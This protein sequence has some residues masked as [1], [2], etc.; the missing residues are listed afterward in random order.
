ME[1]EW[2][3]FACELEEKAKAEGLSEAAKAGSAWKEWARAAFERGAGRA[4]RFTRAAERWDPSDTLMLDGTVTTDPLE[5]LKAEKVSLEKKWRLGEAGALKTF[6]A[7]GEE[8]PLISPKELREASLSF[9]THTAVGFDGFHPRHYS[10]LEEE[11]LE[12]LSLILG[13][14]ERLGAM[15]KAMM[16]FFIFFIAKAKGGLRPLALFPSPYRLWSRAR[17]GFARSWEQDNSRDYFCM[18]AERSCVDTVW[19]QALMCEAQVAEGRQAATALWDIS[20]YY[21]CIAHEALW[22]RGRQTFFPQRLLAL[23]LNMYQSARHLTFAG[24][25]TPPVCV[26]VGLPAGCVFATTLVKVH[27]LTVADPVVQRHPSV[28]FDFWVDDLGASCLGRQGDIVEDLPAALEDLQRMV[29]KDLGC[30]VALP[31][32]AILASDRGLLKALG[33]KLR[34][35]GIGGGAVAPAAPNLGIDFTCGKKRS[36]ARG[37]LSKM[38]ARRTRAQQR[39][40]RFLLIRRHGGRRARFLYQAGVQASVAFGA[41]VNGLSDSE[42]RDLHRH[43]GRLVK[44]W[45]RGRI[46]SVAL[47]ASGDPVAK[48]AVAPAVRWV[49]EVWAALMGPRSA[50]GLRQLT[51]SRLAEAWRASADRPPRTWNQVRGPIGA[52]RLA[53]GRVGWE[54]AEPFAFVD[55]KGERLVVTDFSPALMESLLVEAWKFRLERQAAEKV[56]HPSLAGRRLYLDHVLRAK[57]TA[58]Y[59]VDPWGTAVVLGAVCGSTWTRTRARA[60]G[61]DIDTTCHLCKDGEDDWY[62]RLWECS[63]TE[64]LRDLHA[65]RWLRQRAREAARDDPLFTRGLLAHPGDLFTARPAAD[66]SLMVFESMEGLT[67]EE[68]AF[69]GELFIDGSASRPA[70]PELTRA[71]CA[72]VGLWPDNS[73]RFRLLFPVWRQ[74]P[75]TSQAAEYVVGAATYRLAKEKVIVYS[76]CANVVRD[77]CQ[78]VPRSAL[79]MY[80]AVVRDKLKYPESA[81]RVEAFLKVRAH[82]S[83]DESMSDDQRR[84]AIGNDEAD[85]AA[86]RAVREC[87][88]P[89]DE[90]QV[91][92]AEDGIAVAKAIIELIRHLGKEWGRLPRVGRI[93]GWKPPVLGARAAPLEQPGPRHQPVPIDPGGAI[94]GCGWRCSVCGA[95]SVRKEKLEQGEC[96]GEHPARPVVVAAPTRTPLHRVS[97]ALKARAHPSHALSATGPFL[98]CRKCGYYS[99]GGRVEK[100]KE[101]CGGVPANPGC[102]AL[103]KRLLEGF[104]PD[105]RKSPTV[106]P[107]R[108]S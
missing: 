25:A 102:G 14:S 44:P 91:R 39:V 76:D 92:Q 5:L 47:L 33:R 28:L 64:G 12:A 75:Q 87:H 82:R 52:A 105:G 55:H 29:S 34:A 11:G 61:Y 56:R 24:M 30:E 27:M 17:V 43:A 83:M 49:K 77:N 9:K 21:E 6:R 20:S 70:L 107:V 63:A 86:K 60:C 53:L 58:A 50:G 103:L 46:L 48:P 38:R 94:R 66:N 26:G 78:P 73:V 79:G 40:R 88:P 71:A 32:E 90:E 15:P 4:H 45:G 99:S 23:A 22:D 8:L 108:L 19:R 96:S 81:A 18:G 62:H 80:G 57:N 68:T 106:K 7:V 67:F 98:W 100:L 95:I 1:Q 93:P 35:W 37:R 42:V 16:N 51:L 104:T 59:K 31:K 13:A 3:E 89:I 69:G 2:E 97:V 41:E 72:V 36:S 101:P 10:M 65:P 85:R 54:W 84:L 74:L